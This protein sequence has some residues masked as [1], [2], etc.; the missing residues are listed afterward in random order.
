MIR[1]G[2]NLDHVATLR[3]AR[4]ARTPSLLSAAQ[5][6]EWGG[7]DA[8]VLHLREDRRHVQ[9]ADVE[10]IRAHAGLPLTLEIAATDE[11]VALARRIKPTSVCFVPERRLELTTEGGLDVRGDRD[12][13][14]Q[15]VSTLLDAG[16]GVSLFVEPTEDAL[17]AVGEVG[18]PAIELHVG[19]Y[20]DAANDALRWQHLRAIADAA[21]TARTLGLRVHAGHGLDVRNVGR[22]AA[23]EE[24]E[25]LNIG[26]S[27]VAR[28]VFC[29][30]EQA[31]REMRAAID[32]AR[33]VADRER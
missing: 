13:L 5:A 30:L 33:V 10:A 2:V 23:L 21:R 28:S 29:G 9:D 15:A 22:I 20:A 32:A 8:I 4:R 16:I 14:T 3:Q 27:I 17:L 1:L 24:I 18:A 19:R 31:V 11:M 6:A 25:E 26:F 12:R 7:A